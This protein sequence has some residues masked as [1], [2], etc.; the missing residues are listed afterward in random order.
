V[1]T[2]RLAADRVLSHRHDRWIQPAHGGAA[3]ACGVTTDILGCSITARVRL[4][5]DLV[6][7]GCQV[8]AAAAQQNA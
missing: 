8:H 5:V 2:E 4:S 1:C 6:F 7:D 3:V